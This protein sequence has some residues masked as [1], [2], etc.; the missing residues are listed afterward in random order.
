MLCE[1]IEDI[2]NQPGDYG[3][4]SYQIQKCLPMPISQM[5]TLML[6]IDSGFATAMKQF[7]VPV[8]YETQ[9]WSTLCLQ[10]P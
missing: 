4:T 10:M 7:Q 1:G 9:T 5:L 2:G 6:E 8:A 3:S